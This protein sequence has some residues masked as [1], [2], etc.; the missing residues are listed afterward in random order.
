[1]DDNSIKTSRKF[2]SY[3]D[4]VA[5][6]PVLRPDFNLPHLQSFLNYQGFG[7]SV[8]ERFEREPFL[9]EKERFVCVL[10]GTEE[11][12]IVSSAFRQ[13]L[14]SGVYDD[15][16]P[17]AL[18]EDITLFEINA[19]KYPLMESIKDHILSATLNKGDCIYLPSLYW[20]HT[21]TLTDEAMLITF[22]YEPASKLVNLLFKGIE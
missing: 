21:R 19:E 18:P 2:I 14:Y 3:M 7:L 5:L 9:S 6:S 11:F 15:L 10:D 8:W 12:R 22:T 20:V 4:D 1:M 17:T 13:N 16:H